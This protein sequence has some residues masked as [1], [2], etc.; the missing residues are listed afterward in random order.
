MLHIVSLGQSGHTVAF[1]GDFFLSGGGIL[2]CRV[3][4]RVQSWALGFSLQVFSSILQ[5]T[6][7]KI[8]IELRTVTY[9]YTS[10]IRNHSTSRLSWVK[11]W[12]ILTLGHSLV[13]RSF[14]KQTSNCYCSIIPPFLWFT[15]FGSDVLLLCILISWCFLKLAA[16]IVRPPLRPSDIPLFSFYCFKIYFILVRI[17]HWLSLYGSIPYLLNESAINNFWFF[18]VRIFD[19]LYHL[20]LNIRRLPL[21]LN[22][23][24]TCVTR[25]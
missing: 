25:L 9:I 10:K 20:K 6:T 18:I 2:N 15:F 19:F 21:L 7:R 12:I 16:S 24:I 5:C 4:S 1:V 8:I 3:R 13:L 22:A 17:R 11:R 14:L 23:D